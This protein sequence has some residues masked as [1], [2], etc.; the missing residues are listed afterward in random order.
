MNGV[1]SDY[2]GVLMK[3]GVTEI[4]KAVYLMS[5]ARLDDKDRKMT[6]REYYGLE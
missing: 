6:I 1:Y 5:L 4:P 2:G 3:L